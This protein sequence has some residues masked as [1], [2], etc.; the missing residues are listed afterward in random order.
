[1]GPNVAAVIAA[2][3][4]ARP[5]KWKADTLGCRLQLTDAERTALKITTI[6]AFDVGK[7][8]RL[9]RRK[10]KRRAANRAR[11][12]KMR[13][14]KPRGRPAKNARPAGTYYRAGLAIKTSCEAP[15]LPQP[16]RKA[17]AALAPDS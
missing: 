11:R 4:I 10:K 14:G 3:T 7:A 16:G 8:E 9:E 15:V 2:E 5:V 1:M 13:S 6:G 12:A 17:A